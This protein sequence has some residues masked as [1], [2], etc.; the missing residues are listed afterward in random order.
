[1]A[2]P[3]I[4][5]L[6]VQHV[7]RKAINFV[8]FFWCVVEAE[9][10]QALIRCDSRAPHLFLRVE[11]NSLETGFVVSMRAAIALI[12]LSSASAEIVPPVIKAISVDVISF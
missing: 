2:Y 8:S 4:C 6:S 12:L 9:K 1:M 5:E 7:G 3:V 10:A 11:R